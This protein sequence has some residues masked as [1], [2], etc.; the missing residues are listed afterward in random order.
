MKKT[1]VKF[2][3]RNCIASFG[4]YS[5]NNRV[6]IQLIEEKNGELIATATVNLVHYNIPDG[7]V[8]IKD[9]AEN[10]GMEHALKQAK[11]IGNVIVEVCDNHFI[12]G[13]HKLLKTK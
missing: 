8:A 10:K 1:K 2:Q 12:F 3:Q 11:I 9:Y 5:N 7:F 6:S 4:N 13:I